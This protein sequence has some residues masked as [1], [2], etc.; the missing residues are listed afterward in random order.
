MCRQRLVASPLPQLDSGSDEDEVGYRL[1]GWG[2]RDRGRLIEQLNAH[3]ILHRFEEDELVVE[4]EDEER[5]DDLVAVAVLPGDAEAL[6]GGSGW[7][8]GVAD[9]EVPQA[10]AD[11]SVDDPSFMADVVLLADAARRLHLDP[12]DMLADSD[13][14]EA[15]TAVFVS[16]HFATMDEE[17]WAA[18]GRVTRRLLGVLGAE[19]A[20]EDQIRMEA[21]V[22]AKLLEPVAPG[23]DEPPLAPVPTVGGDEMDQTVYELDEWLPEQ[24]AQLSLLLE[25]A[26]VAYEW[27]DDELVVA[28]SSETDVEALFDLVGGTDEE[29]DGE[30]RYQA[31]AE[32]FAACGRLAGDPDDEQRSAAVLQWA[33]AAEGPPLLGMADIDWFRIMTRL[34][35]L[36][37]AIEGDE[38]AGTIR[39]VA[40]E[41]H[42]LLPRWCDRLVADPQNPPGLLL[43]P[44]AGSD[45]DQSTLVALDGAASALG[46]EVVRMDFPYRKAGRK[47]PDR[48]P[49]LLEAVRSEALALGER[50]GPM[51][52]GGRSMGGRIC[53][54]AV[55]EGV[56]AAGLVLISYPLHPPGRPDRMRTE[57]LPQLH[58]PCLF[59]SGTRDAFATPSE[60]EAATSSIPG[61]VTHVWIDGGDH[62][63]RRADPVVVAAVAKWLE[64][65]ALLSRTV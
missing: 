7:Q 31:V 42:E 46:F 19:E 14:A 17:T 63:L 57:H 33:R 65:L 6:E 29:E 36:V 12:T 51:V 28:A 20:L 30:A 39:N 11:G 44:G 41:L 13:V 18:V 1:E 52:L 22:L 38:D 26:G 64:D 62:S 24:R 32:L 45:R 56:P 47:A 35:S 58:L 48:P 27:D 34:R 43:A 60:L 9:G 40:S 49:V 10:F 50:C 25:Q 8:A 37:E 5:V 4:A 16:D 59:V 3:E 23:P 2:D 21:G 61:S 53:S 54:L 55:T 15:S